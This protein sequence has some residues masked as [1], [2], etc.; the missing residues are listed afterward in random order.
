MEGNRKRHRWLNETLAKIEEEFN[1]MPFNCVGGRGRIGI[2]VEGAPYNYV[3]EVLPKI[4][5]DFKILK[6]S[7]S[8]PAAEEA[9]R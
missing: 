6:L 8:P 2:I 7:T 9:G 5:A 1:S 4:N 3:K